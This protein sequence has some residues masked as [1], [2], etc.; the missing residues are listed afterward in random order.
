LTLAVSVV[1][2]ALLLVEV[3]LHLP[4]VGVVITHHVKMIDE[5]RTMIDVI[6]TATAI[7]NES[8]TVTVTG[9]AAPKT[10]SAI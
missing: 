10:G 4:A 7:A 1:E 5:T 9:P 3:V 8:V 2:N 6:E